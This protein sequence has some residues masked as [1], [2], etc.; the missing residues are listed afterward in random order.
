MML[1]AVCVGVY[2]LPG[3][4]Y[5]MVVWGVLCFMTGVCRSF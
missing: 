5:V 3:V 1:P 4:L 2:F